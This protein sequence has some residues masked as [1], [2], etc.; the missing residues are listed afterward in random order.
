MY[1]HGQGLHVQP[2]DT[3]TVPST[4]G[5]PESTGRQGSPQAR[6]LRVTRN[7]SLVQLGPSQTQRFPG[8]PTFLETGLSSQEN[9]AQSRVPRAFESSWT[10]NGLANALSVSNHLPFCVSQENG[11]VGPPGEPVQRDTPPRLSW[12]LSGMS[13]Q[14]AGVTVLPEQKPRCSPIS[15]GEPGR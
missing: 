7:S 6:L 13:G 14:V 8:D 1:K 12:W 5:D 9:P 4:R 11:N 3:R 15:D 2:Y 10:F